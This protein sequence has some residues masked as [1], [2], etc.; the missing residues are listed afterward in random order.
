[1][2][3]VLGCLRIVAWADPLRWGLIRAMSTKTTQMPTSHVR[4][5]S[6]TG[7]STRD[8]GYKIKAVA[9]TLADGV[10]TIL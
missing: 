5:D 10:G 8:L 3:R 9:S 2:S 7:N 6:D 1:M 4:L